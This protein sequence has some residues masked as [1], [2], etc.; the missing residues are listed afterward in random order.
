MANKAHVNRYSKGLNSDVDKSIVPNENFVEAY[1]LHLA[2]DGKFLA[3]ENLSGTTELLTLDATFTGEVIGGP[4]RVSAKV[5]GVAEDC[6]LAFTK[7]GTTVNVILYRITGNTYE[8]IFTETYSGSEIMLVDAVTYPENGIDIV[9]YTDGVNELRKLRL[10]FTAPI[11]AFTAQQISLQRRAPLGNYSFTHATGGSLLTGSYQFSWRFY[12]NITKTYSKWSLLSTPAIV[13]KDAAGDLFASGYYGLSS[14]KKLTLN[15]TGIPTSEQSVWT[16]IQAAVV[17]NITETKPITASLQPIQ[18][19]AGAT[20]SYEYKS[21]DNVGVISLTDIVVD[22]AAIEYVKTLSVK[23]NRLF[24]ANIK[25]KELEYDRTPTAT[26]SVNAQAIF[27]TYTDAN[28]ST[29]KGHFRDE[30][31]RYYAV[32][33]DDKYNFYRPFRLDMSAITGNQIGNGDMRYPARNQSGGLYTVMDASNNLLSLG[34]NLTV[35][36]HPSGARGVAVFRA[37]RKKRKLFQTPLIPAVEIQGINAVGEYPNIAYESP[38][39]AGV[40]TQRDYTTAVPMNSA[41]TVMPANLFYTKEQHAI[42]RAVTDTTTAKNQAGEVYWAT[43]D[44]YTGPAKSIKFVYEP[45]Y[46]YNQNPYKFTG[47]ESYKVIDF[48]Y[49]RLDYTAETSSYNQ[50]DYLNT[51]IHGTFYANRNVDYYQRYTNVAAAH[52]A[53]DGIDGNIVSS[54]PLTNYGEGTTIGG[55]F[56]GSYTNLETTGISFEAV[57]NNQRVTAVQ[58]SKSFGGAALRAEAKYAGQIPST[59]FKTGG[60]T[61]DTLAIANDADNESSVDVAGFTENST[62]VQA[63]EIAD[64]ELDL[65]DNRYGAADSILEMEFT[66]A[67]HTFSDAEVTT[68]VSTGAVP[69]AFTVYG[70]DCWVSPHNFKIT[71]GHYSITNTP[72]FADT[73]GVW[74][75]DPNNA[76]VIKWTRFFLNKSGGDPICMPVPLKNVSQVLSVVLESEVHGQITAPQPYT[77]E[78][79]GTTDVRTSST[80]SQYRIAFPNLYNA[81]YLQNSDQKVLIP[82]SAN[83]TPTYTYPARGVYS[84]QKVYNTDI[85][86][87]DS[88]PVGNIFDLEETYGGVT[89]LGL[90][91]DNLFA[92]QER[93]IA[94]VPV[95]ASTLST[96][97]AQTISV[98]S[99]T[100]DIPIYISRINGT[101]HMKAVQVLSDRIIFPDN[102]TS[103]VFILGGQEL[104]PISEQGA[105]NRTKQKIGTKL[106]ANQL[107]SAYDEIKRQYFLFKPDGFCLV[108]DDRLELW[109]DQL[110]LST[111][112]NRFYGA[113]RVN[114][115]LYGLG[116]DGSALKVSTLY[117]GSPN[118]FWG[119][120]VTPRVTFVVNPDYEYNKTFDNLIAYA[121]DPLATADISGERETGASGFTVTGMDFDVTRREGY[122]I[123][124]ILRDSNGARIRSTRADVTINWPTD[125]IVSL[126]EVITKYRLSARYPEI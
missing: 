123:I 125:A 56:L 65:D 18:S 2:G 51:S 64:V 12:N 85:Q 43:S 3:L 67:Y 17:E 66:G 107:F 82:Y 22:L 126:S 23:N 63:I 42:K 1:N 114:N 90:V 109:Q 44:Y 38:V 70:G 45:L 10:Y 102:R 121:S 79:S 111:G 120:T 75:S 98:R 54:K 89:K 24:G 69:I 108:W 29:Y 52:G 96:T 81:G 36:N 61:T 20:A 105:I 118:Q 31:Y 71:D 28:A 101:Q 50:F 48:A 62:Y 80:E 124:P 97:D 49:C 11:T 112:T 95:D 14:N 34:L 73:S 116:R 26:G 86:G 37:K 55:S 88:F 83:E 5:D 59:Y 47:A 119:A 8:T 77:S 39:N 84:D 115:T 53:V 122:Y 16:H 57:P 68:V 15:I 117:T 74:N 113:V 21:N 78:V 104:R 60:T 93:G 4:Y 33:W 72:K 110:E 94:M 106:A 27:Q 99:G 9:Y 19:F 100:T 91:G 58:T 76:L 40:A 32:Y 6:L 35:T 103:Q 30:V 46:T 87:F 92:L 25:Y 41:G 13:S 7:E